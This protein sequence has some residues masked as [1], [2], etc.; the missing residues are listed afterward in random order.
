MQIVPLAHA[1]RAWR[2]GSV[3]DRRT[4]VAYAPG[5][6]HR[7]AFTLLELV[8]AA[9]IALLLMLVVYKA[10]EAQLNLVDAG[11]EAVD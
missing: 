11:R 9:A 7:P 10:L 5:S 1:K 2:A 3:S 6:R 4:P 8:L